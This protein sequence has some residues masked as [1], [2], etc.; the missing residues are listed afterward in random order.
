MHRVATTEKHG[1]GHARAVVMRARRF[2]VLAH[3]DIRL[4][5]VAHVIDVIAKDSRD[6]RS[7]FGQDR[8]MTGRSPEPRFPGGNRRF[9]D[10][11]FAL[12]E[13]GMLLRDAH[14]DFRLTGN[15]V[16]VPVT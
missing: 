1:E 15:A 13:I 11:M 9:A 3:I 5:D 6:V 12:V 8:V 4:G 14:H 10:E 7:V 2:A 16:A